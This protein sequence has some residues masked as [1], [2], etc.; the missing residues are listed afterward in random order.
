[1]K[2]TDF[3][4]IC[5]FSTAGGGLLPVNQQAIELI[6]NCSSGEVISLIEVTNRDA[7]FHRAY[8]SL[9]GYIYD[10]LPKTFKQKVTKDK[11]YIFLKHIK[12]DYDVIFEFKDGTK[13]IEYQS[14]AF[15][16]M[17]QKNFAAYVKNQLPFIYTNVIEAL[18][19]N[20]ADSDRI[21]AAIEDEYQKFLTKLNS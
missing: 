15:G 10:W 11:F 17:S 19:I 7:V 3:Q 9:I 6:D 2:D 13:F 1:M 16:R 5:E 12:G 8:F 4:K 14:I 20:V 18:Y 21:I